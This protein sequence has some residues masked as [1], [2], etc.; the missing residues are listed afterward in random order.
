MKLLEENISGKVGANIFRLSVLM[1]IL[2]DL[3]RRAKGIQ[4]KINKWD[5]IKLKNFCTATEMINKMKMQ[6]MEWEIIF[7]NHIFNK[8]LISKIQMKFLQHNSKNKK[9]TNKTK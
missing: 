6:P 2:L 1:L 7:A 4:A 8:G 5:Y 9:Q 3:I